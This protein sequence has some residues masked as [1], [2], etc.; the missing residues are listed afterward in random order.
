VS[1]ADVAVIVAALVTSTI[2]GI[3][4]MGGGI[5]LLATIFC[6]LPHGEAVPLHG[7]VQ[8]VSNGTRMIAFGRNIDWPTLGRFA[9]GVIPGAAVAMLLLGWLRQFEA[10][11]PVLKVAIG[12]YIL[13]ATFAPAPKRIAASPAPRG[14]TLLGFIAG[15]LALTFGATG[16][17]IAPWF[18]RH[19]FVKERLIATKATCQVLTHLLKVPAF[20]L[21]GA[22]AIREFSVLLVAMAA[23]SIPGTLLGKW[24]LRYV[25]ES[26]FR[27]LYRAALVV[28]GSKVL[29]VDGIYRL[30]T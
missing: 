1:L 21:L 27:W 15:M 14:F 26:W 19:N 13:A 5:L 29:L 6:F 23:V 4:G 20:L 25:T 3:L 30:V 24:L 9:L 18:A 8:I 12:V 11:D 16:P 10:I 2:S 17:L 28:A 22:I 7:G